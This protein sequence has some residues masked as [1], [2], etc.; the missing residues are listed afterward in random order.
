M[1]N[2]ICA[3][4]KA[5][6]E[7]KGSVTTLT[8][9][10]HDDRH[11]AVSAAVSRQQPATDVI[12]AAPPP[13]STAAASTTTHDASRH[14]SSPSSDHTQRVISANDTKA[15]SDV[16]RTLLSPNVLN[17]VLDCYLSRELQGC[18]SHASSSEDDQL[19]DIERVAKAIVDINIFI[20]S[21]VIMPAIERYLEETTDLQQPQ[22]QQPLSIADI[23]ADVHYSDD[24]DDDECDIPIDIDPCRDDDMIICVNNGAGVHLVDRVTMY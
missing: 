1:G 7:F 10:H 19:P 21:Q 8:V 6:P 2:L 13:A 24:A 16:D 5:C 4:C 11:D 15:V 23:L 18:L 14:R 3:S 20:T 9:D 17:T 22:Q 12:T